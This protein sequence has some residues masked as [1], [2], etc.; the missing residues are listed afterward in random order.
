MAQG[1]QPAPDTSEGLQVPSDGTSGRKSARNVSGPVAPPCYDA[2]RFQDLVEKTFENVANLLKYKG[3]EYAGD[4][5]RLA[6]FRRNAES[7]GINKETVWAV[8]FGKHRDSIAQYIKDLNSGR[9]R[10]RAEPLGGRVDD[11]ITY[12][13]LLKAML[14]ENGEL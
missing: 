1:F 2:L 10:V 4:G 12:L 6:N 14:D 13:F 9:P 8:Y 7:L 11:M 3:G 5:D